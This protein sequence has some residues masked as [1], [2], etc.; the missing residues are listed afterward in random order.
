MAS[1]RLAGT[2]ARTVFSFFF[3]LP[4][5]SLAYSPVSGSTSFVLT[6]NS[7]FLN[8]AVLRSNWI[9]IL[10]THLLSGARCPHARGYGCKTHAKC[11]LHYGTRFAWRSSPA[12]TFV[13]QRGA[14]RGH[15]GA[16]RFR[17]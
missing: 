8:R 9:A 4:C 12:R 5:A 3:A 2:S 13:A 11:H 16:R 1:L 14:Q 10:L 15:R 7:M 17:D 6:G